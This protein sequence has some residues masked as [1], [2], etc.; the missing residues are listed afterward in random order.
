ME[1]MMSKFWGLG[2]TNAEFS[3][4]FNKL[5]EQFFTE[6]SFGFNKF[7]EHFFTTAI[8]SRFA[9]ISFSGGFSSR[10]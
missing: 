5:F 10:I 3:F 1:I 4:S 9:I 2:V 7:F 8:G 6:S